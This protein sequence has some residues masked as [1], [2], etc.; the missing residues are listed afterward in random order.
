LWR[1]TSIARALKTKALPNLFLPIILAT[2]PTMASGIFFTSLDFKY[3]SNTRN[4]RNR[5]DHLNHLEHL[6]HL[7]H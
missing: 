4:T 5:V 3:T 2:N 7:E 1:F 6:E